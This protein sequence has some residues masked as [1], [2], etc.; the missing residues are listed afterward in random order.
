VTFPE[1]AHSSAHQ[2]QYCQRLLT[3]PCIPECGGHGGLE[4][5]G[6]PADGA[7][8]TQPEL[9]AALGAGNRAAR[10]AWPLAC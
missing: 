9:R 8:E 5:L 2:C 10:C 6:L 1:S 3:N 7:D 4:A